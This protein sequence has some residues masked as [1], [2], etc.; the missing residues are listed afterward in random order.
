M[1]S[2]PLKQLVIQFSKSM[3]LNSLINKIGKPPLFI[4]DNWASEKFGYACFDFEETISWNKNGLFINNQK[5]K[6]K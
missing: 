2:P 5:Y 6:N 1:P 4:I 3:N